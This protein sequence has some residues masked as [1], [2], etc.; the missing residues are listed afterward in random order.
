MLSL[1][2]VQPIVVLV[3]GDLDGNSFLEAFEEC[4]LLLVEVVLLSESLFAEEVKRGEL[5]VVFGVQNF[6]EKPM[7]KVLGLLDYHSNEMLVS[8]LAC[9][10]QASSS[11]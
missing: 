3:D 9:I 7:M 1:L 11:F 5:V 6:I 10:V 2:R 8:V 4:L